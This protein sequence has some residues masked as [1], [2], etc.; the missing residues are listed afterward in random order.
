MLDD[1]QHFQEKFNVTNGVCQGG[2]LSPLLFNVYV[3]EFSECLTK[4]GVGGNKKG[5]II[6]HMLYADMLL[7]IMYYLFI[8]S[9]STTVIKYM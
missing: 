6:N 8:F 1:V 7:C 9:K 4:F 3:N 2:I 5:T